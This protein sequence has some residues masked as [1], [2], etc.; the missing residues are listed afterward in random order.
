VDILQSLTI[1]TVA[2]Q[3]KYISLALYCALHKDKV[4]SNLI[5]FCY[6]GA[7]Q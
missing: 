3:Q 2:M 7:D 4:Q 6:Y 1:Q 5:M